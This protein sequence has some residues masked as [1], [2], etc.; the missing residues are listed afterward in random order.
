MIVIRITIECLC[1]NYHSMHKN[2]LV[3]IGN[4]YKQREAEGIQAEFTNYRR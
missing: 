3:G 4:S 1:S 2:P